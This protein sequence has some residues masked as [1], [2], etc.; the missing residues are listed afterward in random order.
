MKIFI[1]KCVENLLE[2]RSRDCIFKKMVLTDFKTAGSGYIPQK[3][4]HGPL[5]EFCDLC[6]E[7]W[8]NPFHHL[9]TTPISCRIFSSKKIWPKATTV[10]EPPFWNLNCSKVTNRTALSRIRPSICIYAARWLPESAE[11][12]VSFRCVLLV[13]FLEWNQY[14][15][16]SLPNA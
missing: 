1:E 8:L 16:T 6:P 9:K 11:S 3:R 7:F 10:L 5:T 4:G 14:S 2:N 13:N 12:A 15:I